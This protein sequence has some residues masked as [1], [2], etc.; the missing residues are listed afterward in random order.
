METPVTAPSMKRL[1]SRSL[2]G[3]G[4]FKNTRHNRQEIFTEAHTIDCFCHKTILYRIISS[5]SFYYRSLAWL[6]KQEPQMAIR[7]DR[8][9]L[10]LSAHVG[11]SND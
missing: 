8:E 1:E 10:C 4:R 3:K 5:Q 7:P 11:S 9:N 6:L 2:S